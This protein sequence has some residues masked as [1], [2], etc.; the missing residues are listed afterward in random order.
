MQTRAH[1]SRR[2]RKYP[3]YRD[4][5]RGLGPESLRLR[6]Y[7]RREQ[8]VSYADHSVVARGS[9][10]PHSNIVALWSRALLAAFGVPECHGHLNPRAS[11]G[12]HRLIF[13]ALRR[14]SIVGRV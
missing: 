5:R 7:P 10:Q 14:L 1:V 2:L 11:C 12:R 9:I 3:L 4:E 6:F 13:G 8:G